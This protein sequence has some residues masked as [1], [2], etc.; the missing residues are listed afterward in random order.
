MSQMPDKGDVVES[1]SNENGS[2]VKYSDGT[3]ICRKNGID[4]TANSQ[5]IDIPTPYPF[6]DNTYTVIA[7]NAFANSG[8]I[9]WNS[10]A[11]TN[12]VIRLYPRK[13]D[14]NAIDMVERCNYVA[15]GRWK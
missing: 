13:S 2:Y 7:V 4:A 5:S 1:G 9:I 14:G 8:N 3:M 10:G 11:L 6:I 15:I 12:N